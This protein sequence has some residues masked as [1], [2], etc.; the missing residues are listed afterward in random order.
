MK[1][2]SL[3]SGAGGLDSGFHNNGNFKFLLANEILDSPVETYRKN[4]NGNIMISGS[5]ENINFHEISEEDIDVVIGGPPCQDFS[6]LRS[7]DKRKGIDV[8]RGRLYSHFIRGLKNIQPKIFVFEN[9]PGL[10]SAN[11]GVSYKT[12]IEDF[13]K[14][15]L[16]WDEVKKL[17]GNHSYNNKI[18]G[19][20][21][22]FN[23]IIDFTKLGLPQIRRRLIVIGLRQDLADDI[24][25]NELLNI[26]EKINVKLDGGSSL[27][28]RF[29]L[30]PIEVLNGKTLDYLQDDYKD[31]I[32]EYR[33]IWNEVKTKKSND[34]KKDVWDK[35]SFDIIK[36]YTY[37]NDEDDKSQHLDKAIKEHFSLLKEL[38][39]FG[40]KIDDSEFTDNSNEIQK[41]SS[42]VMDRMKQVPPWENHEFVR[43]TKW[44]VR[45]LMSN[46]YRRIHPLR[47]SP[48]I[49]AYGGGGTWG[50][51]YKR[52]RGKLTNRER[53]RLQSFPD[54]FLFSGGV[55]DIRA[56]IG[57]A[58]PPLAGKRI[59]E[60]VT[61]II[62]LL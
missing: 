41:E 56:Q 14:L 31:V 47:P 42:E 27:F 34:W 52:S 29:P 16:R 61:E 1:A 26:K 28:R 6:V 46:I 51:H 33:G 12:I 10:I 2:V 39:Y 21:I 36:D 54:D 20:E 55:S 32:K 44:D 11:R 49:I 13:N 8:S 7:P 4:F 43:G 62:N 23:R 15:N 50:Y 25:Q 59:S 9:V 17:I 40:K 22:M 57:E 48:T 37:L 60:A 5:I 35:L 18:D 30:T 24:D 58:V 38:K 19:Y 45:G 3:F 53:A